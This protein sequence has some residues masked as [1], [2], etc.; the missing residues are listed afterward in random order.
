VAVAISADGR[1]FATGST[2]EAVL[3][4]AATGWVLARFPGDYSWQCPTLSPNGDALALPRDKEIQVW[5]IGSRDR[6]MARALLRRLLHF[7]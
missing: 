2:T 5:E 1:M 7:W 3:Y 6:L 4:D